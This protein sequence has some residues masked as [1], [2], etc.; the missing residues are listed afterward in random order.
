[1]I[2]AIA[3]ATVLALSVIAC[4]DIPTYTPCPPPGYAIHMDQLQHYYYKVG[5]VRD[6]GHESYEDAV[7]AAWKLADYITDHG[8]PFYGRANMV[9]TREECSDE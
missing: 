6:Y 1:M 8:N 7:E 4:E 9:I 2:K 5:T 3:L